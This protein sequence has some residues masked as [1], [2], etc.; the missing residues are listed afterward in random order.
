MNLSFVPIPLLF[1]ISNVG[2]IIANT[3]K[4]Y[5][6]KK[7]CEK[8]SQYYSINGFIFLFCALSIFVF[9]GFKF[10]ISLYSFLLALLFG[11]INM[12]Y[13]VINSYCIKIGPYG[14]TMLISYLSTGFTAISGAIFWDEK[15]TILKIVGIVLM[16]VC[17]VLSVDTSTKDKKTS[18]KWLIFCIVSLILMASVGI[19]QKIHQSNAVYANELNEFL[20]VALFTSTILLFALY[21]YFLNKEKKDLIALSE[22]KKP[23]V[24]RYLVFLII[25]MIIGMS[26]SINNVFNLFLS[27]KVETAIFFPISNGIPLLASLIVSLVFYKEKLKVKQ[28]L[29]LIVGVIAIVVLFF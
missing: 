7:N 16:L 3:I 20:V 19:V 15:L 12:A 22:N 11:A 21:P 4:S 5:Y 1:I 2:C 13:A 9:N 25:M 28:L 17:F 18:I 8:T 29:G 23:K 24:S 26:A 6:I 27:G 10:S 14:Y